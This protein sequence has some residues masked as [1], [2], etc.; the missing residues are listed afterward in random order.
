M[1]AGYSKNPLRV[2][3]GIK[4]GMKVRFLNAPPPYAKLLGNLP[5]GVMVA[6][7]TRGPLDFIHFFTT[8]LNELSRELPA[9]KDQ[10]AKDGMIW[11]SWPK[12]TSSIGA[13]LGENEVRKT[14]LAAGLVDVKVCA[15]DED[16]SGLKF[17]YR[18]KDR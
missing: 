16:W 4:A 18:V 12:K 15:V 9:L 3:L 7:T 1:P 17:V 6:R 5:E 11:V 14:G 2:K 8:S 10:L 13:D